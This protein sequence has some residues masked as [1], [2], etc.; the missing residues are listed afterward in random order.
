MNWKIKASLFT[1]LVLAKIQIKHPN[2][3]EQKKPPYIYHKSEN[4]ETIY[5]EKEDS[6][7]LINS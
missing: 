6:L 7:N 3:P 4:K 1:F 2:P 5:Y